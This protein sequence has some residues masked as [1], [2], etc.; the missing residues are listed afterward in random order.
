VPP[1]QAVIFYLIALL[2]LLRAGGP[3]DYFGGPN[4]FR[5]ND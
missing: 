4:G 3:A 1:K 2:V 5:A